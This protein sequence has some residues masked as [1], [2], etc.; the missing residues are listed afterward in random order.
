MASLLIELANPEPPSGPERDRLLNSILEKVH[1]ANCVAPAP[2]R[3]FREYIWF[4]KPGKPFMRTD[5]RTV[6]RRDT[7]LFYEKEIAQFYRD[8]EEHGSLGGADIDF[9][10]PASIAVGL[11]GLLAAAGVPGS[12]QIHGDDDL[13]HAGVDSLVASSMAN[14]LR[15]ALRKREVVPGG[16]G[17]NKPALTSRLVYAHPTINGLAEALFGVANEKTANPDDLAGLQRKKMDEL[18][19]K[20]AAT[21][22]SQPRPMDV[23]SNGVSPNGVHASGYTVI[24]TGSTGSLGSYLLESLL[25]QQRVSKVYCLNRAEDGRTRQQSQSKPRGLTTDWP[26]DK[27]EFLHADLSKPNFGLD[28]KSYGR[29]LAEI[30]HIIREK[31]PPPPPNNTPR[32]EYHYTM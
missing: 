32:T 5:K 9:S 13:L 1:A 3:I 7:V 15:S 31:L 11:R 18:V 16:G 6:K 22:A 4:T 8:L 25:Q 24:L 20:Y 12:D 17:D 21:G 2:G 26:T 27:V 23:G 28:G 29:L 19:A 30:T 10:S 14:S